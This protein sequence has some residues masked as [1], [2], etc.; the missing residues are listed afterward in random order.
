MKKIVKNK[1]LIYLI[2]IIAVAIITA[3]GKNSDKIIDTDTGLSSETQSAETAIEVH[4]IDVGQ[5]DCS[6]VIC[7]G[8]TMLIDA[9][10]NGNETKVL[11]YLR[12]HNIEKLDYIIASHQHSDHIGGLPEVL[13]EIGT[14]N[15]IMPR[16]TKAQT[17]TNSTYTAF[18][19]SVQNSGA[20]VIA[21][22]VSL[23]FQQ[24]VL[25][26]DCGAVGSVYT[27]GR[28]VF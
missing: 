12:T 1:K 15:I 27:V 18:I 16:L 6:L 26:V 5:G 4:Y 3:F 22:K 11:D 8:K 25:P 24:S 19:K 20:K 23:L 7:D 21:S 17:T 10:E 13:D 9:G 2:I 14:D 28:T